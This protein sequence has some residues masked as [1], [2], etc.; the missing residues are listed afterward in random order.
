MAWETL[1]VLKYGLMAAVHDDDPGNRIDLV[2]LHVS[3]G[4]VG[5]PVAGHDD[6]ETIAC[7]EA[8]KAAFRLDIAG[9]DNGNQRIDQRA[10]RGMLGS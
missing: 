7:Q 5:P 8:F 6:V 4:Q 1:R 3:H 9:A 10:G 2:L